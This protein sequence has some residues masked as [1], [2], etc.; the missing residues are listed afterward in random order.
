VKRFKSQHWFGYFFDKSMVLFD[1][2]I[3]IFNLGAKDNWTFLEQHTKRQRVD[4][5][6]VT[7]YLAKAAY[8]VYPWLI[9]KIYL[10][11]FIGG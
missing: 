1:N 5:Y 3:Q 9:S 10:F 6:H 11:D 2:I 4:F 7:E 8:A